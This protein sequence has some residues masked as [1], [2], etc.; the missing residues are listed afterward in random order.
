MATLKPPRRKRM[1]LQP[2]KVNERKWG[3]PLMDAGYTI[4]PSTILERQQALGLEPTDV[5]I[6]LH[7]A[8]HWGEKDNAPHPSKKSIAAAVGVHPRTVQR[9][10]ERLAFDMPS[11]WWYGQ[12]VWAGRSWVQVPPPLPVRR[13]HSSEGC[14][15]ERRQERQWPS[16]FDSLPIRPAAMLPLSLSTT[17][18]FSLLRGSH[19]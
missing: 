3:K 10:K 13:I 4:F 2:L 1:N 6:L 5:N 17:V 19:P 18:M 11:V 7:L 16:S 14:R 9:R 12:M 8:R 15:D